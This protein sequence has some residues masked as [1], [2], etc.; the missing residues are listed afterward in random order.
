MR[1]T[2]SYRSDTARL[3]NLNYD[4][5]G[6]YFVTICTQ[7]KVLSLGEIRGGEFHFYP[8]GQIA[9]DYWLEIPRH[10]AGVEIDQ[11]VIMPNHMHGLLRLPHKDWRTSPK[12]KNEFRSP[13]K[14]TLGSI[15]RSYKAAVS[16]AAKKNGLALEWQGLYW[17]H[18]VRDNE[19]LLSIREYIWQNPRNWTWDSRNPAVAHFYE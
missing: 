10:H 18:V 2:R 7:D 15:V 4:E 13:A 1:E 8:A 19:S 5:G 16:Y 3:P 12:R 9:H 6:F 14:G 17:D 11:F